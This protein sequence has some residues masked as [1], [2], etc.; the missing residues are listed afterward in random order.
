MEK[1][2]ICIMG[3]GLQEVSG[4]LIEEMKKINWNEPAETLKSGVEALKMFQEDEEE[5]KPVYRKRHRK[6]KKGVFRK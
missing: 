5:F 1:T 2:K 3:S 4:K 6:R